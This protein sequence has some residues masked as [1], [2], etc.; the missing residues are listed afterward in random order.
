M[1]LF[2]I[3]EIP[4]VCSFLAVSVM[5]NKGISRPRWSFEPWPEMDS[6]LGDGMACMSPPSKE[7]ETLLIE[8]TDI[9]LGLKDVGIL[10]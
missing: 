9:C 8:G 10:V 3:L 1:S 6:C 5:V 7:L 4:V 2:S